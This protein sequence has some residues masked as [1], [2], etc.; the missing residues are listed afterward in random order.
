[1]LREAATPTARIASAQVAFLETVVP[2]A[3]RIDEDAAEVFLLIEA[4]SITFA[5][6]A[7]AVP[8]LA[9]VVR[10]E[11]DPG[12]P[13]WVEEILEQMR[14]ASPILERAC[15]SGELARI[16]YLMALPPKIDF[17]AAEIVVAFGRPAENIELDVIFRVDLE[18]AEKASVP[19]DALGLL[20]AAAYETTLGNGPWIDLAAS[21][22]QGL[23]VA[24][25]W[26]LV[27]AAAVALGLALGSWQ[28]GVAELD[29]LE[30]QAQERQRSVLS[31]SSVD[32]DFEQA[33]ELAWRRTAV[34]AD[35]ALE[36]AVEARAP[37]LAAIVSG[38]A[39][40]VGEDAFYE[41]LHA[42]R[43]EKARARWALELTAVAVREPGKAEGGAG[44][45]LERLKKSSL[46]LVTARP[47][48]AE[49]PDESPLSIGATAGGDK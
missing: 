8:L 3:A 44:E 45:L 4:R 19:R 2:K 35:L 5:L 31:L 47:A 29:M 9:R 30:R 6:A 27:A 38:I 10:L 36:A 11:R 40:L 18:S 42:A 43:A 33:N 34:E 41:R 26:A 32:A 13:E 22:R 49:T 25:V 24:A 15:G 28:P 23:A 12:T 37:D 17:P 39:P 7:R 20:C 21:P 1:V 16:R 48:P 46:T 14:Q